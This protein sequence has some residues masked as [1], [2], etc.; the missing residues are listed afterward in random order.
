M[1]GGQFM[2]RKSEVII[3]RK[4]SD[5]CFLETPDGKLLKTPK[6]E[7]ISYLDIEAQDP[8]TQI[9]ARTFTGSIYKITVEKGWAP[10]PAEG[11][12]T[13][14]NARI[15]TLEG[16]SKLEGPT[17][18]LYT[19]ALNQLETRQLPGIIVQGYKIVANFFSHN[20]PVDDQ[21]YQLTDL[22]T[23]LVKDFH[24]IRPNGS[25]IYQVTSLPIRIESPN[26]YAL[27]YKRKSTSDNNT[28]T[29]DIS[30]KL[31]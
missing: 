25:I 31:N 26:Q 19:C 10:L 5:I 1:Q 8:G 3:S 30:H 20:R 13:M 28:E 12:N 27:E 9:I 24:I 4:R 21:R 17:R 23:T 29:E 15:I 7:L 22:T 11:E 2:K 14:R 18:M 6:G 16:G